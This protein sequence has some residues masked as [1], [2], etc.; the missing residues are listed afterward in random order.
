[1]LEADRA[2]A[3]ADRGVKIVVARRRAEFLGVDLR[4]RRIDSVVS[5]ASLI[6]ARLSARNC[7]VDRWL[8]GSNTR[9]DLS[10]SPK[11]SSRIGAA[12]RGI[13]IEYAAAEA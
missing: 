12:R 9:I 4:K 6:G 11:K 8:S 7:P 5:G 13:K 2:A 3:L 10:V 1:M